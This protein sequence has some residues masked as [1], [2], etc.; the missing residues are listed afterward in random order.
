MARTA[1][2]REGVAEEAERKKMGERPQGGKD[3][4]GAAEDE[5][6]YGRQQ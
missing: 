4:K 1:G 3:G 6:G 5:R 2:A